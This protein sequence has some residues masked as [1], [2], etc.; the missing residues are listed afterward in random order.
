MEISFRNNKDERFYQ[1]EKALKSAYNPGMAKKVIQRIAELEAAANPQQLPSNARFHEHQGQRK[2]LFSVD[3]VYPNRL[4]VR[5]TC[6]YESYIEIT[7]V[8]IY[9]IMDPH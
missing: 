5:P 2:G 3:L 4:I 7:S 8:E 9:E 1:D 6:D